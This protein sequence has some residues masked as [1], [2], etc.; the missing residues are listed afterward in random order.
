MHTYT[1]TYTDQHAHQV[2]FVG[3]IAYNHQT[4]LWLVDANQIC[5]AQIA[6]IL[7]ATDDLTA[8]VHQ[9]A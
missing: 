2:Q 9:T 1:I 5:Q 8:V 6:T 4:A 7:T 3:I